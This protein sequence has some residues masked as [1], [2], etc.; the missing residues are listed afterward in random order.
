MLKTNNLNICETRTKRKTKKLDLVVK[1]KCFALNKVIR[2]CFEFFHYKKLSEVYRHQKG[3]GKVTSI[4]ESFCD[5][6]K[7][8]S[9]VWIS[10]DIA[11]ITST[12][13][14]ASTTSCEQMS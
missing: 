1:R 6:V 11:Q 4:E 2:R 13:G 9:V 3:A 7:E 5:A 10:G 12:E 14:E 8:V